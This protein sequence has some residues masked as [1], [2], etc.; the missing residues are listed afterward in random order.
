MSFMPLSGCDFVP[1]RETLAHLGS[2][3]GCADQM[4]TGPK[5][6]SDVSER[7]QASYPSGGR[8]AGVKMGSGRPPTPMFS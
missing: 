8:L 5:V 1:D 7:K 4:T 3:L 6:P 2:P